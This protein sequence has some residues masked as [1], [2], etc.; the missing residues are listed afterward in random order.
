MNKPTIILLSSFLTMTAVAEPESQNIPDAVLNDPAYSKYEKALNELMDSPA[1]KEMAKD[2][3][4]ENTGN[5]QSTE[6]NKT[7]ESESYAIDYKGLS[8]EEYDEVLEKITKN[9]TSSKTNKRTR[10]LSSAYF[11]PERNMPRGYYPQILKINHY[12]PEK[13]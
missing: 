9:I 8:K 13:I 4:K 7:T 1:Y 3:A 11:Y 10:S 6:T 5:N 12:Q 2:N